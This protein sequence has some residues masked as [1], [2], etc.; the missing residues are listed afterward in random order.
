MAAPIN[1]PWAQVTLNNISTETAGQGTVY[2][3]NKKQP[4]NEIQL[5]GLLAKTSLS[6]Q[7]LNYQ[8]DNIYQ[9][10]EYLKAPEVEIITNSATTRTFV[11]TDRAKHIRFTNAS[12]S[13][14]TINQGIATVGTTVQVWQGAAGAVTLTPGSGVTFNV[15]TSFAAKTSGVNTTI[16]A[17]KISQGVGV[18]SWDVWG[19]LGT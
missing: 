6:L 4:T 5:Y 3:T 13:T 15:K 19:D 17:R 7:N 16:F 11:L 10:I 2:Y 1:S 8:F 9:N 14:Y 12:A 18:E